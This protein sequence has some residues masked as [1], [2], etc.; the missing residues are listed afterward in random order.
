M[1]RPR[2]LGLACVLVLLVLHD[3]IVRA[4]SRIANGEWPSYGGDLANG[5][6]SELG[7]ISQNNVQNLQI[8]W[9]WTSVDEELRQ[10]N[11]AIRENPAFWSYAYEVT[12]LM[13][14]GVLYTT[15][16]LGQVAAIDPS[17]G[18]TLWSYDSA[19]Y[20]TGRPAVHGFV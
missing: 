9:T 6:Y 19:L 12:P 17:N 5:K 2:V 18:K 10:R 4:Q 3:M 8:A 7:Q 11:K 13:I 16:S 20:V 14:D 15:T 1:S